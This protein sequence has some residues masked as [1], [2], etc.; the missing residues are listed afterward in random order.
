MLNTNRKPKPPTWAE[1]W[2]PIWTEGQW[3]VQFTDEQAARFALR[4]IRTADKDLLFPML[5]AAP[6][7]GG[8]NSWY[9][10]EVHP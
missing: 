10:G 9:I 7:P 8:G 6:Y 5:A 2:L 1:G 3:I 4:E